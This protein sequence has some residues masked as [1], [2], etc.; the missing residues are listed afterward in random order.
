MNKKKKSAATATRR[1]KAKSAKGKTSATKAAGQT[2]GKSTKG[3][4]LASKTA[5]QWF[6]QIG[7]Q[8]GG[9]ISGSISQQEAANFIVLPGGSLG[10]T[11]AQYSTDA[12]GTWQPLP[13]NQQFY[14]PAQGNSIQWRLDPMGG[15][16]KF[17]IG[18]VS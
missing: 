6:V 4:A 16:V 7:P 2:K 1:N 13:N 11:Y 17:L 14:V 9:V 5:A 3:K 18:P 8:V 10:Q 15:A 12:G